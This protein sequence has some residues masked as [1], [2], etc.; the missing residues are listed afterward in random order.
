[1]AY[2]RSLNFGYKY[3]FKSFSAADN[4]FGLSKALSA[5]S[6]GGG[7]G[8]FHGRDSMKINII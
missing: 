2:R 5:N 7:F 6:E 3:R 8:L 4:T 1:M